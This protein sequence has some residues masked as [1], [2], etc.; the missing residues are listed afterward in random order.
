[1][2][3]AAV[4]AALPGVLGY[5]LVLGLA[6]FVF[7]GNEVSLLMLDPDEVI[8]S[9]RVAKLVR[10]IEAMGGCGVRSEVGGDVTNR[11]RAK[12]VSAQV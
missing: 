6:V 1:M 9:S 3:F 5:A 4:A 7:D 8:L 12:V 10:I 11:L 2:S